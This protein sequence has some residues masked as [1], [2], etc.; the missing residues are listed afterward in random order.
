MKNLILFDI[1]G[2]LLRCGDVSKECLSSAFLKVT[3]HSFPAQVRLAGKTDPLIIREA[4]RAVSLPKRQWVEMEQLIVRKYPRYLEKR[5]DDLRTGSVLLEGVEELLTF[6]ASRDFPL[7]LLT[8]NLESTAR[9]KLDVF[10][11]NRFF[12]VGGFG[13]DCADRNRLARIALERASR[14]FDVHFEPARCW[15]VGD[16]PADLEAAKAVGAKS[17][18]VATGPFSEP[19]LEEFFPDATAP[20]L[21][22]MG[23]IVKLLSSVS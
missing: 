3:G 6:L 5:H 12:P 8:G 22:S 4:F 7:A 16:T 14:H 2:T 15:V 18:G 11:L 17:L 21:T 9:R 20:D 1:D 13:S 10:G 23:D 19:F